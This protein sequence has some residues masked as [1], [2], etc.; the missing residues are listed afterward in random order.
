MQI[1]FFFVTSQIFLYY[2]HQQIFNTSIIQMLKFP[3]AKINIGLNIIGR[4]PDGYH[5]LSTIMLPIGWKDVLEIVPGKSEE[6]A[7]TITGRAIDCPP[8]KNIVMKAYRALQKEV[9]LPAVDIFLRKIIPD[10]AGLGG[11]SADAS[12]TLTILNSMFALGFS[13]EHLADIAA[14][15][16]ADCPLFIYNRPMLATGTGT[17][18]QPIDIS[19]LDGKSILII[20]PP[21]SIST[22]EAYSGVTPKEPVAPLS[23]LILQPIAQWRDTI[24][25]D[26]EAS[27]RNRYPQIDR[28]KDILYN[29]GAVYASLSGSGSAIYGIFDND[30]MAVETATR[31]PECNA[32]IS[33]L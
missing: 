21:F 9:S 1:Y 29:S 26:F 6:T 15:I 7:L 18:L 22:A 23:E 25:N 19:C 16:G 11:G 12:F 10:Q 8:E 17:I 2:F 33:S 5:L 24:V 13:D 30:K 4:R 20:K 27:L 14:T 3:N 32:F 28:Y 31:F